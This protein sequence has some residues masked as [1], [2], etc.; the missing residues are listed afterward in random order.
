MQ[1]LSSDPKNIVIGLVRDVE[2]TEES[3]AAEKIANVH[4]FHGD[5]TDHKSLEAAATSAADVLP[6]GLDVII[7]NGALTTTEAVKLS[8]S[9]LAAQPDLLYKDMH[10]SVDVNVIGSIHSIHAFL[11]LI[12]KGSAKKIIVI[13]TGHA[14]IDVPV[15]F[16]QTSGVTYSVTKAAL[17]MVVAKYAADLKSRDVKVLALSPGIVAT[18]NNIRR[19][20]H[21][22]ELPGR[23]T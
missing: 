12:L 7:V 9:E 20:C 22:L 4:I 15:A 8:I 10:G 14:D 17:N 5:M 2:K 11:P 1:F 23:L 16:D 13:S 18:Q 21:C 6:N 19:F 3:L